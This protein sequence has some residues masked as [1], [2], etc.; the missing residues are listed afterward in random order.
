MILAFLSHSHTTGM[1]TVMDMAIDRAEIIMHR[2]NTTVSIIP[3]DISRADTTMVILVYT[4][5]IRGNDII[6]DTIIVGM[7]IVGA[8]TVSVDIV[9]ADI[10]MVVYH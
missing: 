5:D 8:D 6:V 3:M 7:D 4:E 9:T 10:D 2:V 1:D